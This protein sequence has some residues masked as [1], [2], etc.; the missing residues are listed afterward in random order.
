MNV[1]VSVLLLTYRIL[2][3]FCYC[4]CCVNH[5]LG[6]Y[7]SSLCHDI[8]DINTNKNPSLSLLDMSHSFKLFAIPLP[9]KRNVSCR[10]GATIIVD[11]YYMANAIMCVNRLV[12]MFIIL[13]MLLK[14]G[15]SVCIQYIHAWYVQL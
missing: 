7:I 12:S 13:G 10:A 11:T 2:H 4:K 8:M 5:D 14:I 3:L 1:C 6:Y 9:R 15:K